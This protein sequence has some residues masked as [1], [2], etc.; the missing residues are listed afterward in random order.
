[1]YSKFSIFFLRKKPLKNYITLYMLHKYATSSLSFCHFGIQPVDLFIN[2]LQRPT[3]SVAL[4]ILQALSKFRQETLPCHGATSTSHGAAGPR[5]PS[6][7][8]VSP[9]QTSTQQKRTK[10]SSIYLGIKKCVKIHDMLH[11]ST[12]ND[13]PFLTGKLLVQL[14]IHRTGL[15]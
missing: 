15:P 5:A 13:L 6:D 2:H 12:C 11:L 14:T 3:T 9:S 4:T 1:M 8:A 10:C 7:K